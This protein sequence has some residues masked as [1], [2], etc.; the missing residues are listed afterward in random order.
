[1][2]RL[3]AILAFAL[4]TSFALTACGAMPDRS[5]SSGSEGS[6]DEAEAGAPAESI[7]PD[8]H[9]ITTA[10]ATIVV[11]DPSASAEELATRTQERGGHTEQRRERAGDDGA[12]RASLTVRV[13][14]EALDAFLA[15][16]DELG[17][18]TERSQSAQDVTGTVR[19]LDARIGA[20]EVSIDRLEGIMAEAENSTELLEAEE[21]LSERQGELESLVAERNALDEQVEMSTL[22]V[23]LVAAEDP[24]VEPGGFLGGLQSGWNALLGFVNVLFVALGA[25]LPWLIVLAL[26]GFLLY[27]LLRKRARRRAA[28]RPPMPMPVPAGHVPPVA[29]VPGGPVP[30]GAAYA[31]TGPVPPGAPSPAQSAPAS[32]PADAP[33]PAPQSG[34]AATPGGGDAPRG[35]AS[36]DE[37]DQPPAG[38]DTGSS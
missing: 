33:T 2:R 19:D 4:M 32:P 13:P 12:T 23:E 28:I 38:R 15:E 1:M 20:L 18:V 14:A 5:E 35:P 24:A 16:L 21:M 34:T 36:G 26:P 3:L 6:A 31:T 11:G 10:R 29:P 37:S 9:V 22:E 7:D 30:G 25:L 8:R 17:Q 27:R